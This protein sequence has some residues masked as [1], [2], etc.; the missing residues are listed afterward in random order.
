[1]R[2]SVEPVPAGP[3]YP[4]T[5]PEDEQAVVAAI[6]A[7]LPAE[8]AARA[9]AFARAEKTML[10]T[11]GEAGRVEMARRAR[12][13]LLQAER[14]RDGAAPYFARIRGRF[15]DSAGEDFAEDVR[16]NGFPYMEV[17]SAPHGEVVA[18]SQWAGIAELA[19]DPAATS[20]QAQDAYE[21]ARGLLGRVECLEVK[22]EDVEIREGRVTRV[23]PR[24]GEVWRERVRGR[25]LDPGDIGIGQMWDVLDREQMRLISRRDPGRRLLTVHGP[26]GTGKTVVALH[27]VGLQAAEE[28]ACLYVVPTPAL[29]RHVELGLRFSTRAPERWR[30]AAL[31]EILEELC[32]EAGPYLPEDTPTPLASAKGRGELPLPEGVG[33]RG[34]LVRAYFDHLA[35][36]CREA[37]LHAPDR[38][39]RREDVP[40]LILLALRAGRRLPGARPR[41]VIVD[42]A[43]AYPPLAFAALARLAGD[44]ARFVLAGDPNQR[45]GGG[46]TG[47]FAEARD[48]LGIGEAAAETV[49]LG[50][51]YRTPRAIHA[52]GRGV[53]GGGTGA[54]TSLHE[55]EGETVAVALPR[56]SDLPGRIAEEIVLASERGIRMMAVLAPTLGR[57]RALQPAVT[58]ELR[59]RLGDHAP[60]PVQLLDGAEGYRGGLC[61]APLEAMQGLEADLVVV[62]DADA[63]AYPAG[64]VGARRL[65]TAVT[66]ARKRVA[67]IA[68]GQLTPLLPRS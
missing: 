5:R 47:D 4:D 59:R 8:V 13:L 2:L 43:Q 6:H 55:E 32:P 21:R 63:T 67:L 56:A 27:Y 28:D 52:L 65:Y 36:H 23:A 3:G 20:Y 46:G 53:L 38:R 11:G 49:T 10:R 48:G 17:W 40:A 25:L 26:A 33:A 35:V 9:D 62:A 41:W 42:E 44:S 66:R 68:A 12:G 1:M 15:R 45:L 34:D 24:Y 22:V 60:A 31:W 29:G 7:A 58:A 14:V 19:R 51:V 57:A 61:F 18:V 54:V 16:V 37:G 50:S 30:V 64:Q 39:V